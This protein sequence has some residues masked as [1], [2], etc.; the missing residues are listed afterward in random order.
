MAGEPGVEWIAEGSYIDWNY[1]P[2]THEV[3][4][5]RVDYLGLLG[6]WAIREIIKRDLGFEAGACHWHIG[7]AWEMV[8][9][10]S[11]SH[12]TRLVAGHSWCC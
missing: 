5:A 1:R 8:A 4:W 12:L 3:E 7:L 6:P 10:A 11:G 9:F 2:L